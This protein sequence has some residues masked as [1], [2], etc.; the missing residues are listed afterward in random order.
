MNS[1]LASFVLGLSFA[2]VYVLGCATARMIESPAFAQSAPPG[3]QRWE[4]QCA[5]G[6]N[7]ETIE[8]VANEAGAAGWEMTA[9]VGSD[10]VA[11][12]WCFRRPL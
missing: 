9:A 3:V 8:R 5:D 7:V 12:I 2:G 11:G 4:Y 6:Y 10:R 1:K